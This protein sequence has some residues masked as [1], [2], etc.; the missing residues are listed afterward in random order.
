MNLRFALIVTS[1]V[2]VATDSYRRDQ[3]AHQLG[4]RQISSSV[5]RVREALSWHARQGAYLGGS[6]EDQ[7][8]NQNDSGRDCG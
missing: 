5:R 6:H 4:K 7:K 2:A 3:R 8:D 1:L